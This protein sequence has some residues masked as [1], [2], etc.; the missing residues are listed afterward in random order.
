MKPVFTLVPLAIGSTHAFSLGTALA[1]ISKL[2]PNNIAFKGADAVISGLESTAGKIL[3]YQETR[4]DLVNGDCGDVMLIFARGT[5]EPGNVGA[6]VGPEFLDELVSALPGKN[7]SMQGIDPSSYPATVAQ[8]FTGGSTGGADEM[9]TYVSKAAASC[10]GT[11][12]IMSGWS[13]GAQVVHLA[14]SKVGTSGMSAVSAV[15]TFGDPDSNSTIAGIDSSKV[16]VICHDDDDIC[17][18]GDILGPTHFTYAKDTPAA[19]SLVASV[20]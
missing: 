3:G 6:L 19:A 11:S 20:L 12:I 18:F 8:Y 14:A 16:K 9:A 2:F 7:V 15:V 1:E 4:S 5:G 17:Q 10:T 13:Q